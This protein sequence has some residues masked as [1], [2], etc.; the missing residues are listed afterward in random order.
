MS[1]KKLIAYLF[2]LI[3]LLIIPNQTRAVEECKWDFFSQENNPAASPTCPNDG[4]VSENKKCENIEKPLPPPLL[5]GYYNCCCHD[6]ENKYV[7][8]PPIQPKL[9]T[10]IPGL[11]LTFINNA[12]GELEIPWIGQYISALYDYSISIATVLA[13]VMLMVGGLIWIMAG[14]NEERLGQAKKVI[15]GSVLGLVILACSHLI[16]LQINPDLTNFQSISIN[17][18][19]K[20]RISVILNKLIDLK[21]NPNGEAA[22]FE[23]A[24]CVTTEELEK[25]VEFYS[26]AYF[27]PP[28]ENTPDFFCKVGLNCSCPN[29]LNKALANRCGTKRK[30]TPCNY[31]G[32]DTPYCHQP[33]SGQTL[34]VGDSI[35]APPNRGGCQHFALGEKVCY[36]GHT[37]TVHDR[38]GAI[39]GKRIDI[40]AGTDY[41]LA[42][43][44]NGSAILKKGPCQ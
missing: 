42:L 8:S 14:G 1:N 28:Y 40:W 43:K 33:A 25:G 20:K 37:F 18:F 17:I 35:A 2:S 32:P 3:I 27:K 22:R 26:T 34:V 30:W 9:S 19:R 23:V 5:Q 7:P 29:G 21:L 36:A 13:A 39:T 16:L 15:G 41:N 11:N 44:L 12:T 10:P 4:D 24:P 31:F 6:P 38:G